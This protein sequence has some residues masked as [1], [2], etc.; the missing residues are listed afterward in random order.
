LKKKKKVNFTDAAG[1]FPPFSSQQ[2]TVT[3]E[4]ERHRPD[5]LCRSPRGRFSREIREKAGN[6]V[7]RCLSVPYILGSVVLRWPSEFRGLHTMA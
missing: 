4:F 3:Y 5:K 2:P 1:P 6:H 7:D